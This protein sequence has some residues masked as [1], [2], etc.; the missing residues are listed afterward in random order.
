VNIYRYEE[1]NKWFDRAVKVIPCGV[2]GHFSP[3]PY[4]P[5][6]A[7]P[8][9]SNKADAARFWDVDG[10]EFID[11]MCAYGPMVLG[12]N[13][14]AV[15]AAFQEQHSLSDANSVASPRMVELA[16]LLCDLVPVAE[17]AFF[18]R[19][20]ADVTNLA[21]MV[22]R[23]ATGRDKV[24]AIKG[25]YH[26]TSPW[27]Q[28]PGHHGTIAD[29]H[30]HVIRIP[31][32]D[33]NALDQVLAEHGSQVAAFMASPYHHPIFEDNVLPAEGYWQAVID[34]LHKNGSVVIVDDV[35]AGFRLHLGGSNEHYGFKPDM[36][37]FSKAIANGYALSALVGTDALRLD[38]AK[39]F[40]TGSF[41]YCAG[42][43]AAAIACL[44]T[45]KAEKGP[46]RMR[47]L[48]EKLT[49]GLRDVAAGH[50]Y[51][52]VVSGEPAMP[53][54]RLADDDTLMLQQ[55]WCGECTRRGA[56]FTSHHNWFLSTAHTDGDIEKTLQIADDAFKVIKS[57]F[58]H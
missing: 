17:W 37:A 15:E 16:E 40:H 19:N 54:L 21:V 7:Y 5:V 2:Y 1:S 18:A 24:I 50:G 44:T 3:A 22:A 36:I 11:Y 45:L 26:G 30:Q 13:H 14:P 32:N 53:Y 57:E 34:K 9:F 12:Y 41:W 23:A 27:M 35:R 49:S 6:E 55:A 4:A 20:G 25:G 52:L 8:F 10:N 56:F 31:W 43:F 33:L 48:G 28:A 47:V 38:A 39:V 46:E 29:D 58:G 51:T 42:S